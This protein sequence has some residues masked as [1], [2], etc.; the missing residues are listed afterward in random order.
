MRAKK[1]LGQ[2]FLKNKEMLH[3]IAEA[4]E[5]RDSDMIIEVGPGHGELTE[6]LIATKP[7]KLI[8]I[9]KDPVLAKALAEKFNNISVIE[10][11]ALKKLKEL[12]LVGNWKLVG[13]I[14]Y[15]ITGHLLRVIS[16]LDNP[17]QK[18]VVTVQ[19]EVAERIISVPPKA[20]LLSSVIG[21]WAI[22]KYLFTIS[23]EDFMPAPKVD[24]AVIS[25]DRK[26]SVFPKTYFTIA[27]ALFR[28]PRKKA[29]NNL[30][31]CL[32]V[33]KK[34]AEKILASCDLSVD[35]RPQTLSPEEI[36]C[37]SEKS[38]LCS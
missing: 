20:S 21:G 11:D 29:S 6:F 18:T 28:Q 27:R 8:V 34:E 3:K 19:K 26:E 25:L 35:I 14:P 36:L 5:I 16:E 13:N 17:P 30:S 4:T 38:P 33:S 15:Y 9:E 10:G 7:K 12:N 22:P 2:N 37:L 32:G 1:Y 24:S 31:A 23:R